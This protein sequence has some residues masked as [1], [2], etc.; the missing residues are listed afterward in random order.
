M[1][2][3]E[4]TYRILYELKKRKKINAEE[5]S[6]NGKKAIVLDFINTISS[7]DETALTIAEASLGLLGKISIE[8]QKLKVEVPEKVAVATLSSQLAGWKIS[9]KGG[10]ALAS[11]P[12]RI[13]AKK[14]EELVERVGYYEKAEKAALLIETDHLPDNETCKEILEQTNSKEILIVAFKTASYIGLINILARVVELE[15]FRLYNLGYDIGKILYAK[16]EVSIPKLNSNVMTNANDALIYS[17]FVFLKVNGWD[18][19]LTDKAISMSSK[20]Y[21]KKFSDIFKEY[22]ND[23]YKLPKEI[24]APAKVKVV[25]IKRNREYVAGRIA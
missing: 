23:F 16:G 9:I 8:K 5:F 24:F 7:D 4:S 13:L 11:G 18:F 21:G 25:D 17:S 20:F 12:G 6:F 2:L 3:N 14:P 15:V 1:N 22:G 19:N 10:N